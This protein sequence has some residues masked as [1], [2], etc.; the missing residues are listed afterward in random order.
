MDTDGP[1]HSSQYW[2]ERSEE[3]RARAEEMHDAQAKA[4]M[5]NIAVMYDRM[6]DRAANRE[7]GQR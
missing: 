2:H 1:L 6:A 7:G 3:A 4:T 5:L